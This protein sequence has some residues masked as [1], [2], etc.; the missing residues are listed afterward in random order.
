MFP[1]VIDFDR[2]GGARAVEGDGTASFWAARVWCRGPV[3][4]RV[5]RFR[6]PCTSKASSRHDFARQISR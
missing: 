5:T 1:P 4:T 3:V 2:L 6:V